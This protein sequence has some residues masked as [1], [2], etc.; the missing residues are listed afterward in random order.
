MS[1][2]GARRAAERAEPGV[3]IAAALSHVHVGLATWE[4]KHRGKRK[5]FD[6]WTD[7]EVDECIG[8]D[9]VRG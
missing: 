1:S 9:E 2:E 4:A 5:P 8:E 7:K 6:Q 3:H